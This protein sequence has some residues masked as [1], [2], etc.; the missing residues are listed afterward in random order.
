MRPT[1]ELHRIRFTFEGIVVVDGGAL[2][3][4]HGRPDAALGLLDDVP[5]LVWEM[6]LLA[7][8]DVDVG[9]LRVGE[10]V[11]LRRPRRVVVHP[12]VVE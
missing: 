2:F 12:H 10:R 6:A 3:E 5:G 9:A 1:H 11:Q 7:G 8:R 4:L